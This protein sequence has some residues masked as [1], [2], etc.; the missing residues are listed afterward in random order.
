MLRWLR[1][2]FGWTFLLNLEHFFPF[3][4]SS[5]CLPF[6]ATAAFI[7]LIIHYPFKTVV[8]YAFCLSVLDR[9]VHL[10]WLGCHSMVLSPPSMST[11]HSHALSEYFNES[12][13]V[14]FAKG[15]M[16]L[17][18]YSFCSYLFAFLYTVFPCVVSVCLFFF[19]DIF[20]YCNANDKKMR[21]QLE[22]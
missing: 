6:F 15:Y 10:S 2:D 5:P 1:K 18:G 19:L 14:V 20:K 16:C 22:T 21:A 4:S 13:F 11:P 9:D 3:S 17:W 7:S 12:E 8:F